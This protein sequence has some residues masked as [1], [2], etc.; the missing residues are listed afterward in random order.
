MSRIE[1]LKEK[2][3][4]KT[5]H[6]VLLTMASIGLYMLLYVD[7]VSRIIKETTQ[8]EVVP[9]TYIAW[10][11]ILLG[12]AGVATQE[13][14]LTVLFS[15]CMGLAANVMLVVW[16][17]KARRVLVDYAREEHNLHLST[18]TFYTLIF[19]L[20]YINYCINDLPLEAMRGQVVRS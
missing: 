15:A 9:S 16:A 20:Y 7:R 11:C 13:N 6:L 17:F 8:R 2:T 1:E 3:N 18:N 12:M 19:N 5:L 4:L 10:I 14:E